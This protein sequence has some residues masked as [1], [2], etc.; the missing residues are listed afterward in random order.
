MKYGSLNSQEPCGPVQPCTRIV[1]PL[2][3][4]IKV[5]TLPEGGNGKKR[6]TKKTT[7]KAGQWMTHKM[8]V[9]CAVTKL[10][11]RN[12]IHLETV[13]KIKLCKV[14][15]RHCMTGAQRFETT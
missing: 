8:K 5:V 7:T 4:T 11:W 3:L 10:T 1:L 6:G 9:L 14:A 13:R 15:T 2:P 12:E